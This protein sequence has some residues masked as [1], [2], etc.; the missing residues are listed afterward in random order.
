MSADEVATVRMG[1]SDG[2]DE[3]GPNPFA[4]DALPADSES[5][6]RHAALQE[7]L[8]P[9]SSSSSGGGEQSL[10]PGPASPTRQSKKPKTPAPKK[11]Q[12]KKQKKKSSRKK[13]SRQETPEEDPYFPHGIDVV[14]K[15]VEPKLKL[16]KFSVGQRWRKAVRA[17]IFQNRML[18][19]MEKGRTFR[20]VRDYAIRRSKYSSVVKADAE[21]KAIAKVKRKQRIANLRRKASVLPGLALP[22]RLKHAKLNRGVT[23]IARK[24]GLSAIA[25]RHPSI[26]DHNAAEFVQKQMTAD[27]FIPVEYTFT[28][29]MLAK[30]KKEGHR[31]RG[32][33]ILPT[34]RRRMWFDVLLSLA[35]LYTM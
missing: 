12:K 8:T 25:E 16:L 28:Q 10:A 6:K 32:F 26:L 11:Q 30:Q 22:K 9:R 27:T 23:G 34:S 35:I 3:D 1:D 20:R 18:K 29:M 2:S 7:R 21:A 13:A 17:V 5:G 31:Y 14:P 15:P 24:S 33:V 4:Y 19:A